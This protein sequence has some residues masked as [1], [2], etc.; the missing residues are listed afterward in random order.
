M[1]EG[2]TL[3]RFATNILLNHIYTYED[4]KENEFRQK[5]PNASDREIW[6]KV[7]R[8]S[9]RKFRKECIKILKMKIKSIAYYNMLCEQIV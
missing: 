5:Y 6:E 9:T 8:S 2:I 3:D 7:N 4:I 1:P